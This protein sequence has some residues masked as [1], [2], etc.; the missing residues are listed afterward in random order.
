MPKKIPDRIV[1]A[2]LWRATWARWISL[3]YHDF[4]SKSQKSSNRRAP[5]PLFRSLV[6]GSG[7]TFYLLLQTTL[8]KTFF[9][10]FPTDDFALLQPNFFRIL[11]QSPK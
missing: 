8:V 11:A 10:F 2:R 7:H 9:I 1:G 5:F 6:R 3:S 4:T